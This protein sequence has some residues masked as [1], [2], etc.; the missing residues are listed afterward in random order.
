MPVGF[1]YLI[2]MLILLTGAIY[3]ARG[4]QRMRKEGLS[5]P[6]QIPGGIGF[7]TLDALTRVFD[8]LFDAVTKWRQ[9][10]KGR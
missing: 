2:V 1:W 9:R 6:G 7:A 4:D 3:A 5:R 8:P 10:R